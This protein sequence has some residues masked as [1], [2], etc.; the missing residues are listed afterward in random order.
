MWIKPKPFV[1]GGTPK[2]R[3]V[4]Q[5]TRTESVAAQTAVA[6]WFLFRWEFEMS[7]VSLKGKSDAIHEVVVGID[8][9][10]KAYFAQVYGPEPSDPCADWEPLVWFS[11][12]T[13][14]QVLETMKQYADMNDPLAKRAYDYIVL[15]L[16]PQ[17][18]VDEMRKE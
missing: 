12:A 4:T 10:L 11:V 18:A 17:N 9:P 1:A 7:R 13:R 2:W 15:D 5:E 8:P 14:T 3:S 16:D 6:T